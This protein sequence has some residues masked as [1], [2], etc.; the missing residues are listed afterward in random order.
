VKHCFSWYRIASKKN[1]P[2]NSFSL[3]GANILISRQILTRTSSIQV[4][5]FLDQLVLSP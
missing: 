2:T 5:Y 1:K 3:V 4:F